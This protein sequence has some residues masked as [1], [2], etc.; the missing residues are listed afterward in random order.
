MGRARATAAE[1]VVAFNVIRAL[2]EV[3]RVDCLALGEVTARDLDELIQCEWLRDYDFFDGTL[4]ERRLQFD[5]GLLY[6]RKTLRIGDTATIIA[7]RG[8]QNLRVANRIDLYVA[9]VTRPLH[10]F[11][12]HW[13]SR[14]WCQEHSADRHLL[15]VRLRDAI[16]DIRQTGSQPPNAI[17][18]G[19]Y[20]DEPFDQ[21]LA[22]QLLASRDR[23]LVRKRS[24][25]FYNPFWSH[26]GERHSSTDQNHDRRICGSYYYSRG[27]VTRWHT[28]DQIIFSSSF[29]GEGDWHLNDTQTYI[30]RLPVIVESVVSTA[31]IF[32]HLPVVAK[33]ERALNHG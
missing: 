14:L 24:D 4:R 11:V 32:D 1:R 30:V 15:G 22:E 31:S 28:F 25:L 5:T 10:V 7:S 26:L 33:I 2:I 20:N 12:S 13:P 29:L 18:L 3:S 6:R 21:S 19:D 27:G 16:T 17:L 8:S 23:E 9:G